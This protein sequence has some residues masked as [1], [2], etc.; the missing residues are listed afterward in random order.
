MLNSEALQCTVCGWRHWAETRPLSK[1]VLAAVRVA[2]QR[3]TGP[4]KRELKSQAQREKRIKAEEAILLTAIR[5]KKMIERELE[6]AKR[7]KVSLR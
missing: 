1:E 6:K 4:S 7:D 2:R 5:G 3:A